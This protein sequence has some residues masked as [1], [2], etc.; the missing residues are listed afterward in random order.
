MGGGQGYTLSSMKKD[1][2]I[3]AGSSQSA[4]AAEEML[5]RGGN[6]VDAAVAAAFATAA[7]DPAITSLAGGGILLYMDGLSGQA[8]VCDLFS[9]APGLGGKRHS[10]QG[11]TELP[12]LDF[13]DWEVDFGAGETRQTFH[14]GRAAAAAPGVL[15]GLCAVRDRWA[16]LPLKV[17]LEPTVRF[18]RDGFALSEYQAR[19]NHVLEGILCRSELGR[20]LYFDANS[21]LLEPGD[22]FSN[23]AQ[24]DFLE[25]LG[26]EGI[27]QVHRDVIAP[28]ILSEF[29]EEQG[30]WITRDDLFSWRPIF[31]QAL[32]L[33][34]RGA[35]ILTHPLPSFGGPLL[36]HTLDLFRRMSLAKTKAGSE[37]RFFCLAAV[38]R[39]VSESRAARPDFVHRRDAAEVLG[40]RLESIL[41]GDVG[42][43]SAPEPRPPGNTTH[44]SVVDS[45]CNAVSVTLSY[46][47]GN[48]Y[49]I[50]G[51]GVLMNNF[52]GEADLFPE[53]FH[54][55]TPG[56]RLSTMMA[57]TFLVEPSGA[58]TALGSGG[59]NRI[60]TVISQVVSALLDDGLGPEAAVQQGRIHYEDGVLSA[61]TYLLPESPRLLAS[62]KRLARSTKTFDAPS[63]FFGGVHV[64]CRGADGRLEGVG[65]ARRGGAVRRV[66]A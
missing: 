60:R 18:L 42:E 41:R 39:A 36:L 23:S 32:E 8:E 54:K 6:A 64:A 4:D 46:G 50:P 43:A 2:V 63:L 28:A 37:E 20:E 5:Q 16:T 25:R 29:G 26:A 61:E 19:C 3:A 56:A 62:A 11:A 30:G 48:G 47:E 55:F 38:F 34:Y 22:R 1:G 14:C 53:G 52:L 35:R 7:G 59:S 13:M 10:R 17:L 45:D 15:Q 57:P 31:R 58:L 21:R 51:T 33:D 49:E 9:G 65:D 40:S 27:E 12:P 24:A 66:E 44:I